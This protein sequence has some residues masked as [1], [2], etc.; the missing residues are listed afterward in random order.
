MYPINIKV[1]DSFLL[2]QV[3]LIVPRYMKLR[4]CII[5]S[6]CCVY[7]KSVDRCVCS[8]PS[9]PVESCPRDDYFSHLSGKSRAKDVPEIFAAGASM[10][11]KFSRPNVTFIWCPAGAA[12]PSSSESSPYSRVMFFFSFSLKV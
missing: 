5:A 2:Q 8:V 3:R 10:M 4:L 12:H 7:G 11:I 1:V 9:R 6:L